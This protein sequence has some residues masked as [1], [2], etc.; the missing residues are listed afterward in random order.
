MQAHTVRLTPRYDSERLRR[1]LDRLSDV[2]RARQPGKHHDGSWRGMSL[3]QQGGDHA[4]A[5][6]VKHGSRVLAPHPTALLDRATYFREIV[7]ELGTI[8]RARV[9]ELPAGKAIEEHRDLGN[10]L[11][12]RVCRIH[13]PVVTHPE[14]DFR[15]AGERV[16]FAEGE[17]WYADFTQPHSVHNRS[18]I[19]RVHI[20]IDVI[21]TEDLL[22]VFPPEYIDEVRRR[23]GP[24]HIAPTRNT[25]E[26]SADVLPRRFATGFDLPDDLAFFYQGRHA[27]VIWDGCVDA[28]RLHLDGTPGRRLFATD[29]R[30]LELEDGRLTLHFGFEDDRVTFVALQHYRFEETFEV[31]ATRRARFVGIARLRTEEGLL[32]VPVVDASDIS[33]TLRHP[34]LNRVRV[35]DEVAVELLGSD[36]RLVLRSPAEVHWR[37]LT[38]SDGLFGVRFDPGRD[39]FEKLDPAFT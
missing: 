16:H 24:F 21:V 19:D 6:T 32:E 11:H 35:H 27:Q 2:A 33:A 23:Y 7:S 15:I 4:F 30:T 36:G 9:S 13:V 29:T 1:D 17:M 31:G 22:T 25:A 26:V 14:L 3:C 38:T 12:A 10:S 5:G 34:D 28:Y 37:D 8:Q 39:A 18:D 20:L